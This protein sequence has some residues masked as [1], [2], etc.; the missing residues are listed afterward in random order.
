MLF[1]LPPACREEEAAAQLADAAF[2]RQMRAVLGQPGSAPAAAEPLA[3]RT[4]ARPAPQPRL[5]K[6]DPA[7]CSD[8]VRFMHVSCPWQTG[9]SASIDMP[10]ACDCFVFANATQYG[11]LLAGL[12]GDLPR[13][14]LP[15]NNIGS[16]RWQ[17]GGRS[18][19]PRLRPQLRCGR[20]HGPRRGRQRLGADAERG[21]GAAGAGRQHARRRGWGCMRCSGRCARQPSFQADRRQLPTAV[22]SCPS[23]FLLRKPVA[24]S[25]ADSLS[26][27]YAI[28]AAHPLPHAG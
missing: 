17:A 24:S 12:R 18:A 20:R 2:L 11:L 8:A 13:Q 15:G 22:R 21:R 23:V 25:V 6:A 3:A 10:H 1:T 4:N 9:R 5:R 19:A 14:G 27:L 28:L 7:A 26:R 16:R